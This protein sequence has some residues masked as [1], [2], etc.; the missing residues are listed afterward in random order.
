MTTVGSGS[1]YTVSAG[2][3]EDDDVVLGGGTLED[4]GTVNHTTVSAVSGHLDVF[5]SATFTT[6]VGLAAHDC[7][8]GV[9]QSTTVSSGGYELVFAGGTAIGTVVSSGGFQVV[10]AGGTA[11]NTQVGPGGGGYTTIYGSASKTSVTSS[12]VQQ[13]GS[14]GVASGT[15]ISNG[16]Q[17]WI[18]SGGKS[19]SAHVNSGGFQDILASGTASGLTVSSGGSATVEDGGKLSGTVADGGLIT[20]NLLQSRTFSGTL[21]GAGSLVVSGGS[22]SASLAFS[23]GDQFT[24]SITIS[25]TTLELKSG[26]AAGSGAIIFGNQAELQ[27]D[28]TS[29]PKN[30][31]SGLADGDII[32]LKDVSFSSGGEYVLFQ[33]AGKTSESIDL[34]SS[35]TEYKFNLDP[36]QVYAGGFEVSADPNGGTLITY[37]SGFVSGYSTSAVATG[38]SPPN[39]YGSVVLVKSGDANY[40]GTGFIIGPHSIL[41]AAHVIWY[42]DTTP[43][44]FVTNLAVSIGASINTSGVTLSALTPNLAPNYTTLLSSGG[45]VRYQ[46]DFAVINT[47]ADLSQYGILTPYAIGNT[48]SGQITETGYPGGTNSGGNQQTLIMSGSINPS[49]NYLINDALTPQGTSGSPLFV[50]NGAT[51]E[52]VGMQVAGDTQGYGLAFTPSVIAQIQKLENTNLAQVKQRP[53]DFYGN[54]TSDILFVNGA[55]GDTGF[56]RMNSGANAGWNHIG[57]ASTAYAADGTGDFMGNGTSDVLFRNN[58]NGDTGFYEMVNGA[59][60]GWKDIG[61]STTSYAIVGTGDFLGAGVDDVLFRNNASGDTGF[62]QM[63]NGVNVGWQDVGASST[64]YSVVGTGDFTGD[65]T[66]DILYRNNVTGDTGFYEIVSGVNTGWH[67]IGASSTAY[68]VVG[69]GDFTGSGTDDVLYRNNTTGDTGF[70]EI[71]SGVN[72]GWHD[73]GASSTA[74]SVVAVGDYYDSGTDDILFRSNTTGDTGFYQ[75][76]SGVNQG[77]HDVGA[78][79]TVYHVVN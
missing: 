17:E 40:S 49:Y 73:I 3:T 68:S 47:T 74:Y 9:G 67:D 23:G 10:S 7:I 35:G 72:T 28:G 37:I 52:V 1:S 69:V 48:W 70:Y 31:L 36:N 16:G 11:S 25:H 79:S 8:Y 44:R 30:V 58:A 22:S 59:L 26:T 75:I 33:S 55:S 18:F 57:L 13:I 63:A 34:V 27:V 24:G 64:A 15:Q 29:M 14:G 60:V 56:Y 66:D 46:N 39:P 45:Y 43:N 21:T 20:F 6:D 41:T 4:E 61:L 5:G 32:D 51:V 50:Y 2:S 76:V 42:D 71:V 54:D 53:N 12:G 62:Y 19:I 65:G 78:S 38:K 77:W